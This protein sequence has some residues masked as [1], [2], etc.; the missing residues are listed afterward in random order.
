MAS[1]T[2]KDEMSF[3]AEKIE[4]AGEQKMDEVSLNE[5]AKLTRNILLKLDFRQVLV[6]GENCLLANLSQNPSNSCFT[7]PLLFPR[8]YQC[9]KC[10]NLWIGDG[11]Q[12]D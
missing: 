5:N 11:T 3:P 1:R 9:R 6:Q 8:P 2:E 4:T 7:L 12:H 10:K